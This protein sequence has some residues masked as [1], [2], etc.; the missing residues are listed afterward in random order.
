MTQTPTGAVPVQTGG[1][2][3][4]HPQ[5]QPGGAPPLGAHPPHRLAWRES[6]TRLRSAATTEPGRLRLIGALLAALVI[7]FG[8]VTA[9]QVVDRQ[10]AAGNVIDHSAPLSANAAEIYRSLADADATV[11]GGFL[12]GGE[13]P[14]T[15]SDRY[16]SD[17]T[18]AAKLIADAAAN[19]PGSQEARTQ[20]SAL[21]S[22]LPQYTELVATAQADNRQGLP[23]GGAYLRYADTQ[24]RKPGGLLDAADKLYQAENSRLSA[25]YSDAK[26]LPY[27]AWALGVIALAALGW[28]Q[29]RHFRRTNRV[30]NRGMLAG[31]AASAVVLLWLVA[32]HTVA[33]NDLA[34]SYAHGAKSTQVLNNAR[35]AVLQARGDENLTLVARG[36]GDQYESY[37]KDGMNKLAGPASAK[38]GGEL[39][40]ALALADKDA[41]RAP[42]QSAIDDVRDWRQR[43]TAERKSDDGGDYTTAVAEVIGGKN[44][45]GRTVTSNTGQ[46][47]DGVDKNLG[48]AVAQ[49]QKEFHQSATDGRGALALLPFGAALLAA[50]AAGAALIGIG[51]R[52]S[53]YR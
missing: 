2:G 51:R 46:S 27:A 3:G 32:A 34:D 1:P 47:F 8:T 37:F 14:K 21:N 36:S 50:F 35:I 30:F 40:Q 10:S 23:L 22:Q 5:G 17:I 13:E 4:S 11:A 20:I 49:E 12:V 38:S 29:R 44:S 52:L 18:K 25:D 42:V 45:S 26:S 48:Q 24:M 6:L 9:W 41:G 39:A 28:A 31:T 43:H 7:A 33:R 16:Q 19:S 53:E 15:V